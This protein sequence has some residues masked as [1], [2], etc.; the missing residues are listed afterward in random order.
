MP[1]SLASVKLHIVFSTKNRYPFLVNKEIRAEMHAYLGGICKAQK[2]QPIIVG[3]VE[4]HVHILCFLSRIIT[5]ANLLQE[6]KASSS[7]WVKTKGS[8]L[9]KFSWQNGYGAFSVSE[10]HVKRVKNYIANQ[11]E[12]HRRPTFQKE[13]RKFLDENDIEYDERYVWD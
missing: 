9:T 1:Q 7:K 10:G 5:I 12:H 6:I 3:G 4:D 13:F 2:C 8:L 11:E